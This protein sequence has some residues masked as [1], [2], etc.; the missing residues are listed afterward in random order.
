MCFDSPGFIHDLANSPTRSD[1]NRLLMQLGDPTIRP[2]SFLVSNGGLWDSS[3]LQ[4][5]VKKVN[6]NTVEQE[7]MMEVESSYSCVAQHNVS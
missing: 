3:T 4:E 7:V 2:S 1:K 5:L 6:S